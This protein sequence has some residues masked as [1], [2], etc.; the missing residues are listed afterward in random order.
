MTTSHSITEYHGGMLAV[1]K[2]YSSSW[3][4]EPGLSLMS[5]PHWLIYLL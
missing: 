4:Q 1:Y 2:G 5:L 3:A